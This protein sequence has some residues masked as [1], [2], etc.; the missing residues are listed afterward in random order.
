VPVVVLLRALDAA[1]GAPAAPE[2][3]HVTLAALTYSAAEDARGG[4]VAGGWGVALLQQRIQVGGSVYVLKTLFGDEPAPPPTPPSA[5][6]ATSGAA[7]AASP[8]GGGASE[9]GGAVPPSGSEC[10]ICLTEPKTT[11]ILPCRHLC[12]CAGCAEELRFQTNK[13]PVCRA[14]VSSFL[15]MGSQK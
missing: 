5:A 4:G 11:A 15:V 9:D 10:V 1:T 8:T 2:K 13:C 14:P 7:A 6:A 3:L 12:L